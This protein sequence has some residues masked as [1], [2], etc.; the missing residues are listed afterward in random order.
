MI[1]NGGV[2]PA[3]EGVKA[4]TEGGQ[5]ETTPVTTSTNQTNPRVLRKKSRTHLKQTRINMPGA[6]PLIK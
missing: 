2:L 6:T 3:S 1:I 4:E 5:G